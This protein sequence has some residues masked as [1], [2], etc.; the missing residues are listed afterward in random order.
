MK[1]HKNS[2]ICAVIFCFFIH[3]ACGYGLPTVNLGYT[4]IL[5]GGP[6]RP[7]PG[8]YWQ[9]YSI[10][11]HSH[12]FL[13]KE[14]K[15]LGG[16]PSPVF[17]DWSYVVQLV[18]QFEKQLFF[19]GVPGVAAGLPISLYSHIQNNTLGIK[20]SGGGLGNF[21]LGVYSQ[22]PAI[23]FHNRPF[24]IHRLEFDVI[25]PT[26]KTREPN[27]QINPGH[28][29]FYCEP[30]WAGTLYV[31]PRFGLSW[32]LSYLW[33]SKN[34]KTCVKAGHAI[35]L[36][37][38]FEYELSLI[39]RFYLALVGYYLQQLADNKLNGVVVPDS[40][41]RVVGVGPGIC[42]FFSKDLIFFT[43]LYTESHVRNRPEGLSF[44]LRLVKHF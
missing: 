41:E 35:Y 29:F 16:I 40:K 13:D 26:G 33:N 7:Y 4:N 12:K 34:K 25:F 23:E 31:T 19:G 38:S 32:R 36:N 8:L 17:N 20:D 24:F 30:Y 27:I 37:Y 2:F 3:D 1:R 14:G 11:Y 22:W 10:F 21:G 6:I 44:V 15:L 9:Q 43:Y 42:Y 5:D 39:P 18:Y 28:P